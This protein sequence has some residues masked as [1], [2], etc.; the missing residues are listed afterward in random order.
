MAPHMADDGM[1]AR[2]HCETPVNSIWGCL[3]KLCVF[4]S[5]RALSKTPNKQC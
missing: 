4:D 3:G 2:T 5:L 1:L